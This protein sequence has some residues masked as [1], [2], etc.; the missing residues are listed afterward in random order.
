MWALFTEPANAWFAVALTIMV[1]L[2]ILELLNLFIGGLSDWLDQLLPES[3]FDHASAEIPL[4]VDAPGAFVQFL[5]WLY[6][7]R[8]P[9]LMWLVVFLAVY[10]I[11]GF[12]VQKIYYAV[13]SHYLASWLA[14]ITV[15]FLVLPIVR[16]VSK[17]LYQVL[18]NDFTTA[19][20]S[21]SF[22]GSIAHIVI[23]EARQGSPAQAKLKDQFGQIHY[24]M[25]EPD[26]EEVFIQG[27]EVLL[28]SKQGDIFKVIAKDQIQ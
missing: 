2:G 19:V 25:V 26:K 8:V 13:F 28:V 1:M 27:S 3:L 21:D 16:Y 12:I 24:V 18:P 17:G 7:G 9:I 14:G 20:H 5:A 22:V 6:I 23:G 10:G 4:D 11:T 15:F